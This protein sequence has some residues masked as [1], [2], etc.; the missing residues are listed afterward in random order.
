MSAS[1]FE[2]FTYHLVLRAQDVVRCEDDIHDLVK[3]YRMY[4][5]KSGGK[6]EFFD[7]PLEEVFARIK[8]YVNKNPDLIQIIEDKGIVGESFGRS[9]A[10]Q[11]STRKK[12]LEVKELR[13]KKLAKGKQESGR[14]TVRRVNFNFEMVGLGN[15]TQLVFTPTGA[16]VTAVVPNQVKQN[17]EVLS[18]TGYAKKYMPKEMRNAKD[19]YQG[20]AYFAYKGTKL[21]MLR[22]QMGN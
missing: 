6:T 3:D 4:T 17:G 15:G 18:L 5:K 14:R 11:K 2:D 20:P 21:T 12:Q 9:A 22:E 1:V 10:S 13:R 16:K 7:C 8:K 19:A